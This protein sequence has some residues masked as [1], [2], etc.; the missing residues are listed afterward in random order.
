MFEFENAWVFVPVVI[1][2]VV[3]MLATELRK[4]ATRRHELEVKRD[5]VERGLTVEEI[6]RVIA[7]KTPGDK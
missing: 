5:M 7:A 2:I 4:Y 3:V 6:E 1:G